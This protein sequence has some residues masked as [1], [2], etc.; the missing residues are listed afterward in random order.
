MFNK[1]S[2]IGL[3][4][5]FALTL[6]AKIIVNE[7]VYKDG[8][9][10]NSGDWVEL[11]NTSSTPVD[12]GDWRVSDSK[13]ENFYAIPTGTIIQGYAYLVV[14]SDPKFTAVYPSVSNK[15]GP[16]AL[17]LK[18]DEEV[19]VWN[20]IEE[21]SDVDYECG[22]NDWPDASGNDH[23]I[24]LVY[25]YEDS[26]LGINW[27]ASA[28]LGGS[29]GVKNANACGIDVN[30]HSRLP[31]APD[32][33]DIVE[34]VL[35]VDDAFDNITSVVIR[36]SVDSA[37]YTNYAMQNPEIGKYSYASPAKSDG[38][39]VDYYFII[40]N[41]AGQQLTKW[42][43]PSVPYLYKVDNTPIN[44]GLVINEIMY[45]STD[46]WVHDNLTDS[47]EYVEIFNVT[48]NEI[49]LSFWRFEDSNSKFRLPVGTILASLNYL[50]ITESSQA[51][52][53]VYGPQPAAAVF[54][55]ISDLGL[56]N[57]GENLRLQ[58]ANGQKVDD[59]TYDD[60]FPWPTTPDGQG[61]SLE[62]LNPALD[63]TLPESW[64]AAIE[65]GT[66]GEI[67][68]VLPEPNS[69]IFFSLILWSCKLF[70]SL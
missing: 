47:Y 4:L 16:S 38:T 20:L 39:I 8:V 65:I 68:S 19:R 29:P 1:L 22:I 50:V 45:N 41:D 9:N 32:D 66:P 6:N 43:T 70:R 33:N 31:N 64:A 62:L 35:Q 69:L 7:I 10:F 59:L 14:Y 5:L 67:N 36:V 21:E 37:S 27:R 60:V 15:V 26:D 12:I 44:S 18:D 57:G 28:A 30:S 54:L 40:Y 25:P 55:E 58:N 61:P 52:L 3:S 49:D 2:V 51:L 53:D 46:I 24:E 48:S 63:N 23:S 34:I 17:G 11:F 13:D 42:W 56:S